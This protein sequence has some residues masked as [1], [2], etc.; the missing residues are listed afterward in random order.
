M[1]H[2]PAVKKIAGK[3]HIARGPNK[4]AIV[5]KILAMASQTNTYV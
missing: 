2:L 1:Q 5:F 4:G 3:I